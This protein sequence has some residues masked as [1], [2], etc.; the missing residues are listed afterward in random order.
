GCDCTCYD[1]KD[2][3]CRCAIP[4]GFCSMLPSSFMIEHVRVY[5]NKNDSRMSVGC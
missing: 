1:C 4:N 3:A 5:Q 2:P